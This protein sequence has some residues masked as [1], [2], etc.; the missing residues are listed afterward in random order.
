MTEAAT[1]QENELICER[2]LGWHRCTQDAQHYYWHLEPCDHER[3]NQLQRSLPAFIDWHDAGL[4]LD[5]VIAKGGSYMLEYDYGRERACMRIR[6]RG[7]WAVG[8]ERRTSIEAIRAAALA[9][10]ERQQRINEE[11]R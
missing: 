9:L 3:R 10:I 5:A 2:L 8:V 1:Q 6:V 7:W 11:L 4:I